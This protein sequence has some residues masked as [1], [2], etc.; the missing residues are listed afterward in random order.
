MLK[1]EQTHSTKAG[2]RVDVVIKVLE[3]PCRAW[4]GGE[5]LN[6]YERAGGKVVGKVRRVNG[7]GSYSRI[8]SQH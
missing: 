7:L 3:F 5:T 8:G 2:G 4:V 6:T 1:V